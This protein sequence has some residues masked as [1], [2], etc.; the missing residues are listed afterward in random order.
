[1]VKVIKPTLYPCFVVPMFTASCHVPLP[2]EMNPFHLAPILFL[3]Y[4]F[5]HYLRTY[6]WTV[7][8]L[9]SGSP[10]KRLYQFLVLVVPARRMPCPSH[11]GFLA[12]IIF[13]EKYKSNIIW[14]TNV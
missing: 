1:M 13:D 8:L 11:P 10:T 6:A 7:K 9:P 5:Q 4:K 3:Y 12:E 2:Y 14:S